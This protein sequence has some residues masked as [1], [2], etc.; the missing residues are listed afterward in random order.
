MQRMQI[1]NMLD[2]NRRLHS[3]SNT[4]RASRYNKVNLTIKK[5]TV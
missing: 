2:T 1:S 5:E 3:N 4:V